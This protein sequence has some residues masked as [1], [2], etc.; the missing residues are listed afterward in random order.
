[1]ARDVVSLAIKL[2]V[3]KPCESY[4]LYPAGLLFALM[5]SRSASIVPEQEGSLE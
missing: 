1:M 3:W 2:K 4:K 5:D